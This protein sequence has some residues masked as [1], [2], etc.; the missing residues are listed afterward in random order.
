MKR[1]FNHILPLAFAMAVVGCSDDDLSREN[2]NY[3]GEDVQ[4]GVSLSSE[5]T[6]TLYGDEADGAFP[7]YWV[8]EDKVLMA[9]PECSVQTAEY[10]VSVTGTSSSANALTKTGDR[11]L[12]W[13]TSGT[14]NFYSIYPSA[15][16]NTLTVSGSTAT[17]TVNVE[18]TQ[19]TTC[20]TKTDS[21]NKS[22]IYAQTANMNN[23]V[24]YAQKE[25]VTSGNEVALTYEPL[26][27]VVEF[28][29][30]APT[31]IEEG[32]SILVKSVKLTA[33]SVIAGT[34]TFDFPVD[35]TLQSN[36]TMKDLGTYSDS[37]SKSITVN[38]G[39]NGATLNSTTTYLKVK[40]CVLPLSNADLR[41]WEVTVN[42]E[43]TT[44]TGT[45]TGTFTG[46]VNWD[47]NEYANYLPGIAGQ[48]IKVTL[49]YLNLNETQEALAAASNSTEEETEE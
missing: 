49:P 14:A 7:I 46:H 32:T 42:T 24:M 40:L 11:G 20:S 1:I 15:G 31:D 38:I 2:S 43:I 23:V 27:T 21:D 22:Y 33:T 8:N 36:G 16:S 3:A 29:I 17:A 44:S 28:K 25:D 47:D 5:S 30:I 45:T 41:N 26:S 12:Q 35:L 18:S 4:F 6:R 19:S 39:D 10:Q 37:G 9:S 34:L 13:G 48:V